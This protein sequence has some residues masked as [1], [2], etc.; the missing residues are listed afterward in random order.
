MTDT[1]TTQPIDLT[2]DLA[3]LKD[4]LKSLRD[5][6]AAMRAEEDIDGMITNLTALI[7]EADR[8]ALPTDG[9]KFNRLFAHVTA[10]LKAAKVPA[11]PVTDTT[12]PPTT[13]GP[14]DL[15]ALPAHARM[16]RGY[17]NA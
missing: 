10:A 5:E 6:T 1:T 17:G 13:P 9:T 14:E 11:V 7:P 15:S 3:R 4:D 8:A 16:A 12:R 2:E